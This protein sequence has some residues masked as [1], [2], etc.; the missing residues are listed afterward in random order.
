MQYGFS[1]FV[2]REACGDRH[3]SVNASNLF[4]M[5]SKFA[6]VVGKEDMMTLIDG[7]RRHLDTN[8]AK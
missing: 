2:A 1:P 5:N 8:G 7:I 3:Q 6:E 4:N